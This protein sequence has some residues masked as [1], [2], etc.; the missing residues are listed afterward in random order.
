MFMGSPRLEQ[1][2]EC[3]DGRDPDEEPQGH[4]SL[5][6]GEALAEAK[7]EPTL[8]LHELCPHPVELGV[9][10]IETRTRPDLEVPQV[11]FRCE[12]IGHGCGKS[13]GLSFGLLLRETSFPQATGV[14]KRKVSRRLRAGRG[15]R[16]RAPRLV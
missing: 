13:V 4:P 8:Q 14:F 6:I 1:F 3:R 12:R 10:H 11:R 16:V 7:L 5:E 9:R 15:L 2:H